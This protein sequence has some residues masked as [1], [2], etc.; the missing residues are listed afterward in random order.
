MTELFTASKA[1]IYFEEI[2]KKM[3]NIKIRAVFSAGPFFSSNMGYR[4]YEDDAPIYVLFE[5]NE[6]LII[7]YRFIDL[8][9]IDFRPLN[10]KENALLEKVM[11]KD[12]FNC[13][14]DIHRWDKN[15]KGESV[16]GAID[17]TETISLEYEAISS[18]DLRPVTE[19][20]E[21]WIDGDIDYV[22]PTEDTFD[23]IK[24]T[25]SNG[26]TFIICADHAY[27]DGYVMAWS[28]DAEES[29]IQY[30]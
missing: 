30:D 5:N 26:N 19:E 29:I 11:I 12:F 6:C 13:S 25:M 1:K 18:I 20:Y 27:V 16:V 2:L 4:R 23:E 22:T 15:D 7:D 9:Y 14:V 24:F 3:Q 10:S 21:K 17:H 8:L 28:T